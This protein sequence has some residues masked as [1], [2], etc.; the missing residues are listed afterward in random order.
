MTKEQTNKIIQ[1]V[2]TAVV[3]I[4]GIITGINLPF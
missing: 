4:I 2:I 1:I 3:G